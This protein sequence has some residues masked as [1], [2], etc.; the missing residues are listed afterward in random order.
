MPTP[1][2]KAL[3]RIRSAA[4]TGAAELDL[5][6]LGLTA[7]P[8]EIG[9]LASLQSL[10][11]SGNQITAL[12]PEIGGLTSLQSL[13]L[14]DN[15]LT[16]LPPEIGGLTSLR[17][18]NLWNN[19]LTVLPPEL[20]R[21]PNLVSLNIS[22]N[23]LPEIPPELWQ[24]KDWKEL[25]LGGLQLTALPPEIGGL[26][27][28]QSLNLWGNQI[29]ALPPEIGRLTS[30]QSLDLWH[31][32]LTALPP[33]IGGLTSL[34]TLNLWDNR[35][36]VLPPEIGGLTS[37]QSLNLSGNQIT[38]LPPEIGGLASLQSLDLRGNQI[39]A[40]PP[41]IGRLTSLRNLNLSYNQLTAL[42]PEI[43]RLT[44]LQSLNL[45][46]NQ[47][48]AL[49]PEIGGLTSLQSLD[50]RGNQITALPPEIGRLTSLQSLDLRGNQITALPPEIGR[51]TSLQSLNLSENQLT[52]LPPE[53]G[54]LTSLQSLNLW[55]NRLTTLPPEI[56][57][58]ASLQTLN[59]A[60]NQLTALPPEIGGLTSLQS[61]SLSDN[62]LTALPPAIGGLTSLQN[63]D[64][65]GNRL[66]ALP[67]EIGGLTSLQNLY[68]WGNQ[69]TALPPEIGQLT[70][71]Q[72]LYLWGNQ[73][74]ALPPEIGRLACL[75]SLNLSENQLTALPPEIG[76][77][78]SLQSLDLSHN[79]ITALPPEIGALT[80]L[81][82]LNLHGN[83]LTLA[84]P[85]R[86]L[87][88]ES[89]GGDAREIFAFYR[90][91]WQEGR[92]LNE[93]RVLF[94]GPPGAGKTSLVHRLKDNSYI[95]NRPTTLT[96]ETHAI[97]LGTRTAHLWDFGRQDFMHA[98]HPLFFSAR[99]VYVLVLNVR[100]TY[101]QNRVEYWLRTIRAFGGDSPIIVV[102][103]HADAQGHLL[104]LP[105]NSLQRQFPN[106]LAFVQTSAAEN[107]GIDEL[108]AALG[109][110]VESL[111][112]V[113][114]CFA[115]PH[116]RVKEALEQEKTRRNIIPYE[117]Y[118]E[119]CAAQGI[120]DPGDQ[121]TLL[122]LLHD[123]GVVLDFRDEHGEPLSREGILNPN[124][125]TG[126]IYRLITD[127]EVRGAAAGR[128][129]PETARRILPDYDPPHRRLILDLLQ[130]FE[131]AYPAGEAWYLPNA[132][133]QDE[134]PEAAAEEWQSA[135]TF[136][137]GYS[138]LPESVITRFIVRA[139]EHIDQDRVWRW[140][141]ILAW[142]GNRAL[143]RA[144]VTD[145]K[146]EIRVT[147][148]EHTRREMLAMIR[149]HFEVIH[150]TFTEGRAQGALEIQEF[151]CPLQYPGLRLDYRKLLTYEKDGVAR[152][153]ET[154]Q[155][156]T[157]YLEVSAL[158]NGFTTPEAR[159]EERRRLFPEE[160]RM[161]KEIHY[162]EHRHLEVGEHS[163]VIV[164]DEN[165]VTQ[166]I[167]SSFN[168]PSNPDLAPL[169]AQ[170]TQAVEE[171]LEKLSDE[172]AAKVRKNLKR[173]QEELQEPKPQREWYSVSI[174]GLIQAAKNVGA[175]GVPVIELAGKILRLI[176]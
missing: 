54:G 82:R 1:E 110:A 92:P 145:R 76:R 39:T 155:G 58:L 112:H 67:A 25:G 81:K 27:S 61:L 29:T 18:L 73:I 166:T 36:T 143:V 138:Q 3:A 89:F 100:H 134:P 125:V 173:L 2:E 85:R 16:A 148:P 104:D 158:L 14:Q 12:L 154:W 137:Y 87:G 86:L 150:R 80:N 11:L 124:W 156:R 24:K 41:E 129:T 136:E 20:W 90:A 121:A 68:L 8:P 83:P 176:P 21:L 32:H 169:L 168:T 152:I 119:L 135:L 107:T 109:Q 162:H 59:L 64:L 114:V 45:S 13:D 48:T 167:Q 128:L 51:L 96:V 132:M 115:A 105:Q 44:S 157:L 7:L 63:L 141:V 57:R 170:L 101:E 171:M 174:E 117:R 97:P 140:G 78:T 127:H 116:L 28:L 65:V 66:T 153:P 38:A 75:Q 84:L 91:I 99:C 15:R 50:L 113:R 56:G 43:G 74:T 23:P 47:L 40:L 70:S 106:I 160:E 139:H 175:I 10:D 131:L 144:N 6:L 98:T 17:N 9:R 37:L 146:V 118:A 19:Q 95:E 55:N 26:I 126:A 77:L 165:V 33:E 123:L 53:I 149:A 93:A 103:N 46:R 159:R 142:Q 130:R 71:L 5:S 62:R 122:E 163:I 120:D 35:L 30:L 147:G 94:I 164:G 31:N 42:P 133:R 102:G 151:I 161:A 69:I 72:N 172:D 108:R 60:V 52:A 111:P 34:Q 4:E 88:D 49:P 22:F 79:Q